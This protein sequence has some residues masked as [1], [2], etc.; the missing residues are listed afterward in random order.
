M[1]VRLKLCELFTEALG[2]NDGHFP[3]FLT[4]DDLTMN[5]LNEEKKFY[6]IN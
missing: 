6:E 3:Y 4:F 2:D 1:F 5:E